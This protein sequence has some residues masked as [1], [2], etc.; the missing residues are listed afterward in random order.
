MKIVFMGTSSYA[1]PSLTTIFENFG[2]MGVVT[3][4]DRPAHRGQKLTPS[5]VKVTAMHLNI[6]VYQPEKKS[7]IEELLLRLKPD[8]VVVVAYGKILT[9]SILEIP[10]YGCINLHASLLPKYRGPAP[11]QRCLMSGENLTGNTVILM[12]EGMDTGNILSAES[13]KI[14]ED[15]NCVSLAEK[16]SVQG[17]KL[18]IDTLKKWFEG[19]ITPT[20]QAHEQATYAPLI[21]KE[22]YRIC[23]KAPAQSVKDRIRALYPDCYAFLEGGERIK[24]LKVKV[25]QE[26]GEPG[27]VM[28]RKKLQV[29][30]GE[31]CVEVLEL[32]N[33]KGKKVSGEDFMRGYNPKNLI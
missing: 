25:C 30:C 14:E 27:E 23:W 8:C 17:A 19:K 20:A 1:V 2:I 26:N 13:L 21:M 5:P 3:Q 31:G 33:P 28:H 16:L 22:E 9:R 24:I 10:R 32:I 29:A 18:L 4:P 15:D 7:Q 12:D 6:P 11:I